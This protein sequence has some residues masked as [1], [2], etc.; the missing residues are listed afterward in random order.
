MERPVWE[1]LERNRTRL[2]MHMPGHKGHAPFCAADLYALDTTELPGTDDLYAPEGGLRRAE[3][4]YARAAGSAEALLLHNGSTAGIQAMLMLYA[5]AGETVLLPRNAHLS[6]TNACVVGDL[7]PVYMPQTFTADGYGYVAEET[8]LAAL[9]AHSEAKCLLVTRPDFYG[10]LTS[11]KR[12]AEKAHAQGCR[13]VVDEAHG[14]HFAASEEI[15]P[16]SAVRQ[17]ADLVVQSAHKTLATMNQT[18]FL[19][20]C[21]E[22]VDRERVHTAAKMLQTSSPSYAMLATA[23]EAREMLEESGAEEWKRIFRACETAR[24]IL[25][26]AV[27]LPVFKKGYYDPCRL[28]VPVMEYDLTGFSLAE[29]L[30][31]EDRID[32]EMADTGCVV[33][34]PSPSNSTEEIISAAKAVVRILKTVPKKEK[35]PTDLPQIPETAL[36]P[37][38]AFERNGI[39]MDWE[40]AI[41]KISKNT[42]VIYPPGTPVI[43]LGERISRECVFAIQRAEKNGAEVTGIRKNKFYVVEES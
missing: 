22:Q 23:D 28:V 5:R 13:L 11:L 16:K 4:C 8:I 18:A 2:S 26:E 10:C 32:V 1:M 33:M 3:E 42:V 20:I 21:S 19:H 37:R 24:K 17:G 6:A 41:G 39:W 29:R 36:S 40:Q 14:A 15:F 38:E 25:S 43:V 7:Q 9:A 34:L 30:R 35:K 31:C 12:I 27:T